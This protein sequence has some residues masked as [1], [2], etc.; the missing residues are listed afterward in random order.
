MG[1]IVLDHQELSR[2]VEAAKRAGKRVVFTNG[3]FDLLHVGHVRALKGAR[4]C[5]DLLVVALNS[6]ASIRGYK[7]EGLPI[8]PENER[9]ELV[10]ELAP[11]D[12][13]T[14]FAEPTVDRL[15]LLLKPHVHA[16]GT[17]YKIDA[18]PEAATVRSYGGEIAIVG[19]PK[20]HSTSWLLERIRAT[21]IKDKRRG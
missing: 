21:P 7:G 9:A 16:K 20:A 13:V 8:V 1:E 4:A 12:L 5:G 15:L 19:D 11:V 2:R 18:I 6:D 3:G 14:V 17:D 10:A